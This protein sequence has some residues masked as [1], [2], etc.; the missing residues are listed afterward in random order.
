MLRNPRRGLIVAATVLLVMILAVAAWQ[1]ETGRAQRA[2]FVPT[3]S[4]GAPFRQEPRQLVLGGL[5]LEHITWS[6]W[7]SPT[8]VARGR[9]VET[10]CAPTCGAGVTVGTP[11]TVKASDLGP[12]G[13]RL[14]YRQLGGSR[15]LPRRGCAYS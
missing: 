14:V 7:G 6:H 3:T 5:P 9:L 2:V 12:C 8:A 10:I 11:L 13:S 15:T 4:R 1:H